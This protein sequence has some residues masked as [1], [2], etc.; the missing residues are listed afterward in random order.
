[1]SIWRAVGDISIRLRLACYFV[2]QRILNGT[3]GA[4]TRNLGWCEFHFRNSELAFGSTFARE[5]EVIV[6]ALGD[7]E[8]CVT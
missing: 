6:Y 3:V 7:I 4:S 2:S 1:M 8:E 5:Q